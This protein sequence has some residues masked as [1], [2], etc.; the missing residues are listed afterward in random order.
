VS[1]PTSTSPPAESP[2]GRSDATRQHIRGSNLLLFGRLVSLG[3]NFLVN[4]LT[5]RYLA[6]SDYGAFSYA[7]SIG[8]TAANV[9]LLGMPR[10][11]SRYTAIYQERGDYPAMYGSLV[12]TTGL[13]ATFGA[14]AMA[15]GILLR[16]PLLE[17]FV[18]DPLSISLLMILIALAPLQALD[19]LFQSML[20]VFAGPAAIF[21]RRFVLA[22]LL[23]LAS[24]ALVIALG[25][26]VHFLAWAYLGAAVV[27]VLI[28]GPMLKRSLT[29]LG[30]WQHLSWREMR[31]PFGDI[32]GFGLP[33]VVADVLMA[34]RTTILI[35]MLESM[36]GTL[37]VADYRAF[38]PIAGLNTIVLQ[39][40][41]LLL[42]PVASKLYARDDHASIDELY[43]QTTIWISVV[44]FPI[45]VPC[46]AMSD[47][48]VLFVCGPEYVAASGV[49][50][51][52]A[53]GEYFNAAMGLNTYTLQVYGRVR[54][55][56]WTTVVAT[57]A[58]ILSGLWL[59]PGMGAL[60]AALATTLAIVVQNVLH[61]YGLHRLTRIQLVR[62]AYLGVYAS[63][64]GSLVVLLLVDRFLRPHWTVEGILV[65]AASLALLRLHRRTMD[66]GNVFP[67]LKKLPLLGRLLA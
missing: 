47:T 58:G 26:S 38:L 8:T 65:A 34:N 48:M 39:S 37:A 5:V 16:A 2:I 9:L 59:I 1:Q 55:L 60:G 29:K 33:L 27:G 28:Y 3:V 42:M 40:M 46:I 10:S 14:L 32:L 31:F 18:S 13:I 61:H 50:V 57:A 63:L 22:P 44:T 30:L 49:L 24:V 45:F 56:V 66:I 12:L 6:K 62:P 64:T 25:G 15:L 53:V 21:F 67:E 17:R 52:L 41:K 4:V 36:R 51:A 11:V 35:V 7:L 19:S 54:F 43:W 23:R 20:A